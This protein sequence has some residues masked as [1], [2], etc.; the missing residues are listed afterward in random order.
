MARRRAVKNDRGLPPT[1]IRLAR[2]RPQPPTAP[3]ARVGTFP[4]AMAVKRARDPLTG[5]PG[6]VDPAGPWCRSRSPYARCQCQFPRSFPEGLDRGDVLRRFRLSTPFRRNEY[7]ALAT[8]VAR[9]ALGEKLAL[10]E[11][12]QSHRAEESPWRA[13][14]RLKRERPRSGCVVPNEAERSQQW[15]CRGHVG[16]LPS[17]GCAW[18]ARP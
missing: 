7:C 4:L 10:S 18:K 17:C 9:G 3:S 16:P 11:L 8:Q 5:V 6:P 15:F 14:E 1:L 13:G 2:A 12:S